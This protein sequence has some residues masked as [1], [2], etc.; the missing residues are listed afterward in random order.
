MR[1][2]QIALFLIFLPALMFG[3]QARYRT[4]GKALLND[5]SATPGAVLTT[6][7]RAVCRPGYALTVRHV[8]EKT[9]KE[10]Y[11]LYGATEKK[12]ICCEVDHLISLEL[13]GSNALANLWPEP[14]LP[15]PGA[16]EK[17][18]VEDYLHRQVC[19]GKLPLE[20]AQ[21]EIA[22]DWYRIYMRMHPAFSK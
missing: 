17:D 1:G 3:E 14:Y 6:D 12:G 16:H 15:K 22:S 20:E 13:G 8:T 10:A 11:A 4:D 19:S 21:K 2:T 9:K 5:L 7:A 18:Q